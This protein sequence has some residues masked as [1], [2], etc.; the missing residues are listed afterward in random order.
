MLTDDDHQDLRKKEKQIVELKKQ[1]DK[2]KKKIRN[3]RKSLEKTLKGKL[4]N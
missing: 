2:M 3:A 4:M 1:L